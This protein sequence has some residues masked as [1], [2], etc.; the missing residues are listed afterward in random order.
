MLFRK[1]AA[2][3]RT[4]QIL[5]LICAAGVI[6]VLIELYPCSRE[7]MPVWSVL[8]LIAGIMILLVFCNP[9]QEMI[10]IDENGIA[11]LHGKRQLWFL[12]WDEIDFI[13]NARVY[14]CRGYVIVPKVPPVRDLQKPEPPPDFRIQHTRALRAALERYGMKI[15]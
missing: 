2:N 5:A 4:M 9:W 14:R 7:E 3:R 1:Y 12:A 10:C 13:R 6:A 8:F 15:E 11:C